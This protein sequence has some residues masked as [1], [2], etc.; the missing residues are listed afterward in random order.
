MNLLIAFVILLCLCIS[1]VRDP[2]LALH[3]GQRLTLLTVIALLVPGTAIFQTCLLYTS[4][5]A[6]E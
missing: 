4:D 3:L 5:A 6:D 2:E 1:E